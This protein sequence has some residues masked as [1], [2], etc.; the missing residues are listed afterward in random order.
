MTVVV[1]ALSAVG[2]TFQAMPKRWFTKRGAN[3]KRHQAE[4]AEAMRDPAKYAD[5]QRRAM[6][7][8]QEALDVWNWVKHPPPGMQV[9]GTLVVGPPIPPEVTATQ[10]GAKGSDPS[11]FPS[12]TGQNPASTNALNYNTQASGTAMLAIGGLAVILLIF[13]VARKGK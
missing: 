12:R 6:A 2:Q 11:F 3:R 5:W 4:A 10:A 9:D 1:G 8:E 13:L 7:G